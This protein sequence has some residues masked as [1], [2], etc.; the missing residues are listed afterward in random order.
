[1]R[2][3]QIVPPETLPEDQILRLKVTLAPIKPAIYRKIDVPNTWTFYQLHILI[4]LLFD[5]DNAHLHEF[6]NGMESIG[7]D[8]S[9]AEI[10]EQKLLL[11][12][13]LNAPKQKLVYLYD[14]GDSWEHVI[15]VEKITEAEADKQYPV[16]VG[17]KRAAPPEDVGGVFGFE[18]FVE[19]MTDPEHP[20]H[21]EM[22]EWY[23]E[24][25]FD[26][27]H[28]S[29]QDANRLIAMY[30]AGELDALFV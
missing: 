3:K 20:E 14:F 2:I 1:M 30:L 26:R 24:E 22:K 12:E 23:G 15:E 11:K 4:Q 21:E 19:V 28:F 25:E 17:G 7:T 13:R 6:M 10:D 18:H 5:W 27:E 16:C 8:D 9:E 29:R